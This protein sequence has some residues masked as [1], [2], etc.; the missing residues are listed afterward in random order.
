MLGKLIKN[1]FKATART[2]GLMYLIVLIANFRC[3]K[4]V[5]GNSESISF[6][7]QYH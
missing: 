4:S 1:E 6:G 7:K 2:F 3:I 5:Y